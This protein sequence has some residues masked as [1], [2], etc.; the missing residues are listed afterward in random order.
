M[1]TT[2]FG[3]SSGNIK[4]SGYCSAQTTFRAMN[5]DYSYLFYNSSHFSAVL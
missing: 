1:A 4:A 3:V 5:E 2:P